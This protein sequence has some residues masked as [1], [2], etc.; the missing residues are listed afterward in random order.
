[1]HPYAPA[2][3]AVRMAVAVL[4]VFVP[5]W[6][7]IASRVFVRWIAAKTVSA[8]NAVRTVAAVFAVNVP[9]ASRVKRVCASACLLVRAKNAAT[10]VVAA[11]VAAAARG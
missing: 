10:M 7:L 4:V 8:S 11:S 1:M 2:K 6:P 3:N 5:R 9:R